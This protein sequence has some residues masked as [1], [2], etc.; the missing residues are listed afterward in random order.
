MQ[1]ILDAAV[2]PHNPTPP[3]EPDPG[4]LADP[5]RA[6]DRAVA[7]APRR[8]PPRLDLPPTLSLAA[9]AAMHDA[10]LAVATNPEFAAVN[11]GGS[12]T[13]AVLG[14]VD[15]ALALCGGKGAKRS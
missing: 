9:I 7:L 10:L 11:F 2:M 4:Q 5:R 3:P 13:E 15:A 1:S 6:V 8:K 12:R 14:Q